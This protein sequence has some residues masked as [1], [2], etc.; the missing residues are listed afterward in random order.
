LEDS[1]I[2]YLQ[3]IRKIRDK[4]PE[5]FEII[6][7]LPKKARVCRDKKGKETRV[8][9]YFR[10]GKIQKFFTANSDSFSE[11][12]EI[13][14][15]ET[16]KQ[17]NAEKDEEA[18]KLDNN[19]YDLL[20]KNMNYIYNP[21]KE[22]KEEILVKRGLNNSAKLVKILSSK[23]IKNFKGFTDDDELYLKQIIE[24]LKN[25]SIPKK[26]TQ[27]IS[28]KIENTPEI[29]QNPLKLITVLK[30]NIPDEFLNSNNN[31]QSTQEYKKE[32]ILSEYFK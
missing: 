6:K 21:E 17:M 16:A 10:K 15:I 30:N 12:R 28:K 9:T 26:I 29:I 23:D 27:I 19:F 22:I 7:R 24:E 4:N 25:S 20:E 5:L 14:F 11:P 2:K 13:D 18:V 8:L 32:I 3:D 31:F 1:E